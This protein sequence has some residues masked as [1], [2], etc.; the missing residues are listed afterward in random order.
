[1]GFISVL[2]T[3]TGYTHSP[4]FFIYFVFLI[5]NC[6]RYGLLMSLFVAATFNVLYVFV[7][8]FAPASERLPSVLGGEGL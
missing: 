4:F 2:I 1:M 6:L 3:L 8:G 7:L 5:S